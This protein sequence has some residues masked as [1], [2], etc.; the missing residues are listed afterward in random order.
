MKNT[1]S[2]NPSRC[3]NCACQTNCGCINCSCPATK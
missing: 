1:T 3:E 2:M